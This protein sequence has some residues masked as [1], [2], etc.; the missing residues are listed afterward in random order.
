MAHVTR[1]DL[2]L[3]LLGVSPTGQS[4]ESLGGITRLQKYLFLLEKEARI[5]PSGDGFEFT[6]Y[7]A[8]PYSSRL[9]DDL[10]F[11]ANLGFIGSRVAAG[12]TEEETA[13]LDY[14][15]EDL[16][17]PEKELQHRTKPEADAYEER[18]FFITTKGRKRIQD[19]LQRNDYE[20]IADRIRNVKKKF[21]R[22]SLHDLLYYVYTKYP[23]M[24]TESE[25]REKVL[26]RRPQQ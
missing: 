11:L 12:S 7:K 24:T 22:Y 14:T 2:L 3:L 25:I 21:A 10:E 5:R 9:Y 16:I 17:E 23:D 1:K 4:V 18:K 15:F 6:P 8:G 20:D 13:E 19:L 26:R